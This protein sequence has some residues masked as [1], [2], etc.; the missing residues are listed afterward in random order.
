MYN[1]FRSFFDKTSFEIFCRD[2]SNKNWV[3]LLWDKKINKIQGFSTLAFYESFVKGSPVG[4]VFSGDTIIHPDYRNS[5]EMP[6]TWIKIVFEVGTR[7]PEPL[8]W[9]LISSGYKT[10]RFLQLFFKEYYPSY[11]LETPADIQEVINI[12]ATERFGTDYCPESGIVRFSVGST[13]LKS[14]VAEIT[15]ARMKDPHVAFF[16]DKNPGHING[17]ELVCLTHIHH[18]NFTAAAKRLLR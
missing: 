4:V 1:L 16:V 2:L 10:Y 3:V 5:F 11:D 18:D 8:Y 6:R 14:G 13:P 9:L 15:D 7:L 12:L 17:D